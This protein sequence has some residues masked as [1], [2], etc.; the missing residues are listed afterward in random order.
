MLKGLKVELKVEALKGKEFN[1]VIH[2]VQPTVQS[3]L[4]EF[5]IWTHICFFC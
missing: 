3:K 4:L 5:L 2:D 1:P